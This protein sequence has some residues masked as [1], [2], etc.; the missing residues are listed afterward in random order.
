LLFD[1]PGQEGPP[2]YV[3]PPSA[4][5]PRYIEFLEDNTHIIYPGIAIIVVTLIALA[6]IG[7]WRTEDMDGIQKAEVKREIVRALRQDIHGVTVERLSKTLGVP[8]LRLIR[9][10]E[11]MATQG[12]TECRT[13][14]RRVTTWRL[15]GLVS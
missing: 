1:L 9:L 3:R 6:V 10:L 13:D 15:K 8:S 4:T 5:R 14:T 12:I 11:E 7:A 2:P